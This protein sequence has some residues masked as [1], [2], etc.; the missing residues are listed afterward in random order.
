[1][2]RAMAGAEDQTGS[3]VV[4]AEGVGVEEDAAEERLEVDHTHIMVDIIAS[5]VCLLSSNLML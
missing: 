1:V 5:R 3:M 2:T 4:E